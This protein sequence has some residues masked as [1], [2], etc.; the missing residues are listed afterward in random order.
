MY[1][2]VGQVVSDFGAYYP[3]PLLL[4]YPSAPVT[5]PTGP[6]TGIDNMCCGGANWI[7]VVRS[8]YRGAFAHPEYKDPLYGFRIVVE[9]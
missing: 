7:G 5:D 2:N 6:A 3:K 1:G 9:K 8:A 4:D